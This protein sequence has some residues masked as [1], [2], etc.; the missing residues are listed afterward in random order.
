DGTEE[1]QGK[2]WGVRGL[3]G[4]GMGMRRARVNTGVEGLVRTVD[5]AE[6]SQGKHW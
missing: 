1:S 5:G 6:E 3:S 2:H 4:Q